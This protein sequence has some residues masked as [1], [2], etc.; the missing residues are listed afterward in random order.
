MR[1][2]QIGMGPL[3]RKVTELLVS[4]GI[5]IAA[6]VDSAPALAGLG[7]D[8]L[9]AGAPAVVIAAELPALSEGVDA[10]IVTTSS[11]LSAC[12]ADFRALL[13]RGIAVVSSCEELVYPWRRHPALARELEQLARQ[14]N[15]RL[16]GTGVNPGYLMDAFVLAGSAVCERVRA[17][18][19]ERIQDALPRRE[20]FQRKIGA[21]MDPTEL[22][23]AVRAGTMGHVGL[24]ESLHFVADAL[25]LPVD[26]WD[27]Q[28]EAVVAERP[29]SCAVGAI[30]P[31]RARGVRQVARGYAGDGRSLVE[32]VFH[33]AIGE[34]ESVDRVRLDADPPVEL[35]W[36]G[37]VHGDIATA[38]LLVNA[39]GSL[40]GAPAGL[41]TMATIPLPHCR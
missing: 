37:G 17:V 18:H 34:P 21:T 8:E 4:R 23:R 6:A 25:R 29:L 15:G 33:A 35:A 30:A 1:V 28:V 5:D 20:P 22:E 9:V 39:V 41:H 36:T 40:L 31:G 14:H 2:V 16:L 13:A 38:A 12:A 10:A 3:G 19:I 24:L 11:H 26:R 7:L 32:L 27:E